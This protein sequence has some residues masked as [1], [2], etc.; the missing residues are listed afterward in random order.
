MYDRR[1]PP[2]KIRDG[3]RTLVYVY[4]LFF[5]FV[6]HAGLLTYI[7]S[8]YLATK[9]PVDMVGLVYMAGAILTVVLLGN[10]PELLRTYGNYT[11]L[12][13]LLITTSLILFGLSFIAAPIIIVTLFIIREALDV[14][15]RSNYDIYIEE[16]SDPREAG[17]IRGWYLSLMNGALAVGPFLASFIL[18]DN[19]Y[20]KLFF[21]GSFIVLFVYAL[22]GRSLKGVPEP[23][24]EPSTFLKSAS[25]LWH[26]LNIRRIVAANFLLHLFFAWM[27][28]YTPIYLHDTIGFPWSKLGLIFTIMLFPYFLFAVPLGK[29]ADGKLGEKE[30]LIGGFILLAGTTLVMSQV[31]GEHFLLWTALLFLSRVG[32]T[33][34]ETMTE[35]YF[36]K[37]V[38]AENV[39]SI[40]IFRDTRPLAYIVAP[41]VASLFLT[42]YSLSELFVL[43]GIVMCAGIYFVWK[44]DDTR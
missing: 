5:I 24:Y 33:A 17:Q 11:I 9:I 7:S 14:A 6:I 39:S 10:M 18:T 3:K 43:V 44:L 21:V 15:I 31:T 29:I 37:K 34:V 36:F 27:V 40:E 26:N 13:S 23:R 41:L 32:A 28:I 42:S 4:I 19:D 20:W 2:Q 1:M 38:R 8:S 25:S 16:Y 12:S 22:V 35:T 30:I